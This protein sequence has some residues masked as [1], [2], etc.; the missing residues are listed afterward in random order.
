M[1]S[2]ERLEMKGRGRKAPPLTLEECGPVLSSAHWAS[3]SVTSSGSL[4]REPELG[5]R[6]VVTFLQC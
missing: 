4:K 1:I 3:V 6:F 5:V 2:E